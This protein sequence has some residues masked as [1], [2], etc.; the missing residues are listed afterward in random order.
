M[1]AQ[2]VQDRVQMGAKWSPNGWKMALW[3]PLGASWPPAGLLE[4]S[5]RPLGALLEAL[6]AEKQVWGSALGRPKG[7]YET[8]F[9]HLGGQMPSQNEP[10]RVPNPG[11]KAIQAENGDTLI[12]DVSTRDFNDM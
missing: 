2:R 6:G 3:K 4:R 11:P 5:W 12:F 7:S 9:S 1:S 8:G 10:R